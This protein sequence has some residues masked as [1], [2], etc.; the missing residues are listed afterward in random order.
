MLTLNFWKKKIGCTAPGIVPVG[1]DKFGEVRIQ[2]LWCNFIVD[3]K[4]MIKFKL[5]NTVFNL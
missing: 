3:L 1:V 2:V 4:D 5:S